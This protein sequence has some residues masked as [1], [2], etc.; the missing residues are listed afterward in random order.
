MGCTYVCY[1]TV[2]YICSYIPL[3]SNL[4]MSG[5]AIDWAG[6]G[7]G[8]GADSCDALVDSDAVLTGAPAATLVLFD[9]AIV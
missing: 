7:G 8:G 1:N 9:L 4:V 6:G 5:G 2:L 3:F